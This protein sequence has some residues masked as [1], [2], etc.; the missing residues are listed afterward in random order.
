ME[1]TKKINIPVYAALVLALIATVVT[2]LFHQNEGDK[3]ITAFPNLSVI[4]PDIAVINID[5]PGNNLTLIRGKN[6]K[7][8]WFL[9]EF[10]GYPAANDKVSAFIQKI[11]SSEIKDVVTT[12]PARYALFGVEGITAPLSVSRQVSFIDYTSNIPLSF[13]I[14]KTDK[15]GNSFIRKTD[16]R[17]VWKINVD[18][19]SVD[20]TVIEWVNNKLFSIDM[21]AIASI[22]MTDI[23]TDPKEI[24]TFTKR[25][26]G[27]FT[28]QANFDSPVITPADAT[29]VVKGLDDLRFTKVSRIQDIKETMQ[30]VFKTELFLND[31]TI[32]IINFVKVGEREIWLEILSTNKV[33]A[34]KYEGWLYLFPW[35]QILNIMPENVEGV[36]ENG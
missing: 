19:S 32:L 22:Q 3:H 13:I 9:G 29:R 27:T 11:A 33:Y 30:T 21:S 17:E 20:S 10:G 5:S 7:N 4:L 26:D 18:L 23:T 2:V 1:L 28:S 12:N 16:S 14:G 15:N 8:S 6:L 35:R 25:P 36:E 24:V 31:K 34:E